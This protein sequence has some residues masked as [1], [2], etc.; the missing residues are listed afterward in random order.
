MRFEA[1]AYDIAGHMDDD[2]F[3]AVATVIAWRYKLGVRETL[4]Y[5]DA[6]AGCRLR[7]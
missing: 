6:L 5:F 2:D 7:Q 4:A 1:E 3:A